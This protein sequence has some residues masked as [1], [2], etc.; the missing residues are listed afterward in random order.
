MDTGGWEEQEDDVW[1]LWHYNSS[2]H[3]PLPPHHYHIAMNF[4]VFPCPNAGKLDYAL[5]PPI[6]NV[7]S[8][9]VLILRCRLWTVVRKL[10]N[11]YDN[12]SVR[13]EKLVLFLMKINIVVI[14]MSNCTGFLKIKD[15]LRIGMYI[16]DLSK[17]FFWSEAFCHYDIVGTKYIMRLENF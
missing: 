14:H 17:Y 11:Y 8:I 6:E 15:T 2:A 10:E 9:P 16:L 12:M 3:H 7:T 13:S 1:A 5:S 4:R